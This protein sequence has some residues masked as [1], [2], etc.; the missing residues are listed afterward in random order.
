M[1]VYNYALCRSIVCSSRAVTYS[2]NKVKKIYILFFTFLP[3][4]LCSISS[5]GQSV[6]LISERSSVR[7][8]HR[9]IT[10]FFANTRYKRSHLYHWWSAKEQTG[11]ADN[12]N[13]NNNNREEEEE[14][15]K[16]NVWWW[17][18]YPRRTR[19]RTKSI[20]DINL[21][22]VASSVVNILYIILSH[23]LTTTK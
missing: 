17:K 16:K 5:V 14:E 20:D 4:C 6:R 18:W 7:P 10:I 1:D 21:I 11:K 23:L 8:R 19:T 9:A 22:S 15:R 13:N 2:K 3:C 12:N